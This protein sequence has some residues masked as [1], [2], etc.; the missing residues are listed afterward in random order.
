MTPSL[1]RRL[2]QAAQP[3]LVTVLRWPVL[4]EADSGFGPKTTRSLSPPAWTGISVGQ[5]R[6]PRQFSLARAGHD[7]KGGFNFSP[8]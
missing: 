4:P 6:A 5:L 3:P 1:G 8:Y 2:A 7:E